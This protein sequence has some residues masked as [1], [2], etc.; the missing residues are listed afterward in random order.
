ML[1]AENIKEK[2][3]DLRQY[4]NGLDD[5]HF[6]ESPK[7]ITLFCLSDG[8]LPLVMF[9]ITIPPSF[10]VS[11]YVNK[12]IIPT[13]HLINSFSHKLETR[14][15]LLNVISHVRKATIDIKQELR[16]IA[17]DLEQLTETLIADDEKTVRLS[18]MTR[19]LTL[20]SYEPNGRR[21]NTIDFKNAIELYLKIRC[22][23]RETR[24]KS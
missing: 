20:N 5:L 22:A 18:I 19:Q 8:N 10:S 2:S 11:R 9:S 14:T 21:Y 24:E 7:G 17:N 16:G 15:Q 3:L 1:E 23:Y 12:T 4:C 13:F 6:S